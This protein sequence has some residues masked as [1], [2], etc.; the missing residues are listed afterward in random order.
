VALA[1]Q[2]GFVCAILDVTMPGMSGDLA[3]AEIQRIAPH[4]PV[5]I[6]S[7]YSEQ[8]AATRFAGGQPAAFVQKPYE[9]VTF[10]NVVRR[11][12]ETV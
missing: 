11:V 1:S 4:L 9:M 7:G 8:E 6:M 2:P 3:L 12:V 5:V 10:R